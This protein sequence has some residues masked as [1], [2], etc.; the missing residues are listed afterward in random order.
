MQR[1]TLSMPA[2][3]DSILASLEAVGAERR[4]RADV[5][6]LDARVAALKAFQQ[7][8]FARTYADLLESARYGPAARFFLEELYGP[9]DFVRRDAQVAR[10]ISGLV[11][12]FPPDVVDTV[13]DVAALHALSETLDTAM[14]KGLGESIIAAEYVR[15][16]Q[17]V[18][19]ADERRRQIALTM[20]VATRLD[21]F[22]RKPLLRHA[23]H[24]MRGPARA[25]GVA[26]LQRFLETGFDAFR[27]MN[28]AG[29][30]IA[31]VRSREQAFADE[32]FAADPAGLASAGVLT[33][34]LV[35]LA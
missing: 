25:A 16:W 3:R 19:R 12:L 30:F 11:K 14:A 17:V 29:E 5:P 1:P 24:L 26:E 9:G 31:L 35:A 21:R 4:Q 2:T 33:G 28:G 6:G 20:D 10:V 23:L 27:A 15:A 13:A 34:A 18:G 8:R 32:L 22:T 7:R